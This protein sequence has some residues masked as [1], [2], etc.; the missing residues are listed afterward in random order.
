GRKGR[1]Y[2]GAYAIAKFGVEGLMQVWADELSN[3]SDVRVNSLNPGATRTAM[4]RS[5]YPAEAVDA[6]PEPEQIMGAY[7]FLMGDDSIGVSGQAL[8][9]RPL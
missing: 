9:A 3:T 7:L 8:N 1:A 5:A 2:W 4:R 6:N